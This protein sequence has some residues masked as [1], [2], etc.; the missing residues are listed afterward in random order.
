[1][2]FYTIRHKFEKKIKLVEAKELHDLN[3]NIKWRLPWS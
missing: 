3:H 1:M 2:G